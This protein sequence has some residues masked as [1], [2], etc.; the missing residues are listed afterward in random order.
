MWETDLFNI[1]CIKKNIYDIEEEEGLKYIAISYRWGEMNEQLVKT[2]DYTAHITSFD[3]NDFKL[4]CRYIE[5]EKDLKKI[6]YLWIDAISVDQHHHVRKKE[7]IL[8]MNEIYKRASFI[9]AI[10]D[11]HVAYL[12]KNPANKEALGFIDKYKKRIYKDILKHHDNHPLLTAVSTGTAVDSIKNVN[13]NNDN[14][15]NNRKEA[16]DEDEIGEEE[17]EGLKKAYQF[18]AYLLDDWSNRAWVISEYHIAK[19]KQRLHGTPLKYTFI[20][21]FTYMNEKPFFSYYFDNKNDSDYLN[22]QEDGDQQYKYENN[23]LSNNKVDNAEKFIQFVKTRFTQRSY[24]DM[25]LNSKATRNEDRFNAIL[26]SWGKYHHFIKNKYT[27]S[28]WNITDMVSVRLK[29]YAIM[30]D[31][32]WDKAALLYAC[33]THFDHY[34]IHPTFAAGHRSFFHLKLI[35]KSDNNITLVNER[36][37]KTLLNHINNNNNTN[38]E[39]KD[40]VKKYIHD[41]YIRTNKPI[42]TENLTRIQLIHQHYQPHQYHHYLSVKA[43]GYFIYKLKDKNAWMDENVL[44]T[45]SLQDGN[46]NDE[47]DDCVYYVYIPFFIFNIPEYCHVPHLRDSGVYLLGNVDINKWILFKYKPGIH[48]FNSSDFCAD[49]YTFNIS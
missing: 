26:S 7:T 46:S 49:D 23:T 32:L 39:E 15:N 45:L 28:K 11:L 21:L 34:S 19:E 12:M 18:L 14:N 42:Y 36:Y 38:A 43:N 33:S 44:S 35:E 30:D 9:L 22:E 48:I 25:I 8:K 10:P 6:R 17:T 29:L 31:D 37:T 27:I 13:N 41:H 47:N 4:L 2:P 16:D 40:Y 3:I 1:N 5:K 24:L 20:S